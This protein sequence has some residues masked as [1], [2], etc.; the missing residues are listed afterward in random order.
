MEHGLLML[1]GEESIYR[2]GDCWYPVAMLA[3]LFW[4]KPYCPQWFGAAG[5]EARGTYLIYSAQGIGIGIRW[6]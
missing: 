4:M 6:R 3:I 2:L 5:Q 1:A